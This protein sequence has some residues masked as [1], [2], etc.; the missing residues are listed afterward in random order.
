MIWDG[1][2]LVCV[3]TWRTRKCD[4]RARTPRASAILAGALKK[5]EWKRHRH[6][7]FVATKRFNADK[8]DWIALVLK[9]H[10]HKEILVMLG[11]MSPC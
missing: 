5:F 6:L 10:A 4:S 1:G 3:L 7:V 9:G 8:M 2:K 11:G